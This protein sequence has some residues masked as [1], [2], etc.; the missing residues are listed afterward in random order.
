MLELLG[1]WPNF[2]RRV[3]LGSYRRGDPLRDAARS[4]LFNLGCTRTVPLAR[5]RESVTGVVV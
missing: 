1:T 5:R 2:R 4:K 3:T